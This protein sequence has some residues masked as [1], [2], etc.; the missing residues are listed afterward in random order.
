[1]STRLVKDHSPQVEPA[2][3]EQALEKVLTSKYFVNAHKK[4]GF[5]RLICDLYLEGRAH[6]V[7]EYRIAFDVFG[8]DSS[9]NPSADPI[10]RVVAHEIRKKLELYYQHEGADDEV[11]LEIPAGSYQP[12]F[13][14]PAP[15]VETV[16]EPQPIHGETAQT[17]TPYIEDPQQ[18][19]SIAPP[20]RMRRGTGVLL[21][22]TL[23]FA[24]AT[25]VLSISNWQLRQKLTTAEVADQEAFGNTLWAPFANRTTPPLVIVSNPPVLGF[26]NPSDPEVLVRDSIPLTTEQ[27]EALRD[28]FVVN[29]E[30][31]VT[32][33]GSGT[34][35]ATQ[36]RV[37]RQSG[38]RLVA[39]TNI[40]T[41]MGE[42]IGLHY[43][44]DYFRMTGRSILLKQ[45]RTLSAEDL[46]NHNVIMLGGVWVN[47]WAGKLAFPEDFAFTDNGTVVNH[48]P[49]PG[50]EHE[51]IPQFDGRTGS[52]LVDYALITVK[53]NVSTANKVMVLSGVYSPGT[54]AAVEFVTNKTYLDQLDQRLRQLRAADDQPF[55]F[56]V[57][58]KVGVENGIPTTISIVALHKL[59]E[60][61]S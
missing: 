34:G 54:E 35:D 30:V 40:Q 7:N 1:M 56:Q 46:K 8:R 19:Q 38:A 29:P 52:L 53:P 27:T 18:A 58:L 51:Y 55:Y 45:S 26:V 22:A 6:E 10:V 3:V 47:A 5:L 41:G 59:H 33:P 37:V 43:L 60:S 14:R 31:V 36:P 15:A 12:I 2:E 48:K 39:R 16:D 61:G 4:K 57:L 49:Q 23:L 25:G 28:I 32:D 9:Y 21:A 44:T 17:P 11:R 50:E 20:T 24:I 13:T 42:A